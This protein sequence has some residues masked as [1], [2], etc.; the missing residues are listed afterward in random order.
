MGRLV[1]VR[2]G[3][4]PLHTAH[5]NG[6]MALLRVAT[7]PLDEL[8]PLNAGDTEAGLAAAALRGRPFQRGNRA[9]ADR[10]PALCLLGVPIATADPR[11]RSAMR[12]AKSY[13]DRRRRELA[14]QHGGNL[15][16]GPCAMLASGARALGA[17]HIL[18]EL[19]S[20]TLDPALFAQAAKLADSARGQELTAVALA[21][22][23]HAARGDDETATLRAEQ[24]AFQKRLA[25]GK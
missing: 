17:S 1:A 24:A 11:Y 12:K 8:Q 6:A 20:V 4:D 16:A 9:G 19:A 3:P 10:K 22:R 2:K 18:Y 15:G 5:G 23:E 21:A 14:I 7:P 13:M 25:E